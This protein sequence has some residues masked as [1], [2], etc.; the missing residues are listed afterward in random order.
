MSEQVE[1]FLINVRSIAKARNIDRERIA[2]LLKYKK[3][4]SGKL[5]DRIVKDVAAKGGKDMATTLKKQERNTEKYKDKGTSGRKYAKK[6]NEE[7]RQSYQ[8][9]MLRRAEKANKD[10][11]LLQ[12]Y[13]T[14]APKSRSFM[15]KNTGVTKD[16]IKVGFGSRVKDDRFDFDDSPDPD[17]RDNPFREKK[18][19][20]PNK[21]PNKPKPKPK[22]KDEKPRPMNRGGLTGHTDYRKTGMFYGGMAKKKK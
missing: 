5:A 3:T 20:P 15:T 9:R 22:P 14:D 10:L 4:G 8:K 12:S 6:L 18:D 11:Q 13:G 19:L 1:D 16:D 7:L 21:P 2:D 17:P